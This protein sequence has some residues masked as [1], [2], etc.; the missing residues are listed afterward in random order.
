M[1]HVVNTLAT[2]RLK[3]TDLYLHIEKAEA[4]GLELCDVQA[5]QPFIAALLA[6]V[7]TECVPVRVICW[8]LIPV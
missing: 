1:L 4:P 2:H 3:I 8:S 7:W 5:G 6:L